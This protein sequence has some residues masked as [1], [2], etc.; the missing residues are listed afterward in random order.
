MLFSSKLAGADLGQKRLRDERIAIGERISLPGQTSGL[1]E[2][3][4]EKPR[5]FLMS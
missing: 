3:A 1:G 4:R 2:M 5:F